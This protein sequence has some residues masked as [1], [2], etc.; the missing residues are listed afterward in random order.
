[1]QGLINVNGRDTLL[2]F[3]SDAT[4]LRALRENGFTEVKEGCGEGQCGACVVILEGRL[5]NACQIFAATA[6][7]RRIVTVKGLGDIHAPHIVQTAFAE[8]GAIQ[9]GFCTPGMVLATHCLLQEIP[10]PT[11][12]QILHALDGNLC[13]CTGY[14]KIIDAVKLAARKLQAGERTMEHA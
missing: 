12:E 5:V 11:E 7:G 14:E 3:T 4:L 13:R 1:M 10:D 6:I 9:C 2:S 8:S